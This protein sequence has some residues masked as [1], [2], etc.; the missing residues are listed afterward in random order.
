MLDI[1]DGTAA[2]DEVPPGPDRQCGPSDLDPLLGPAA[3]PHLSNL[4]GVAPLLGRTYSMW[5]I[6]R[7]QAENT[8]LSTLRLSAE[9]CARPVRV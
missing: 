6:L 8:H 4:L 1:K 7:V 9:C 2:G 3:H 5:G